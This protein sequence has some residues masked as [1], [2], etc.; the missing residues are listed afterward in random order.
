M[1][2]RELGIEVVS[3]YSCT[4]GHKSRFH[5][6]TGDSHGTKLVTSGGAGLYRDLHYRNLIGQFEGLY[7]GNTVQVLTIISA[8]YAL[9]RWA[10]FR[11]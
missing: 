2:E 5:C 4:G 1:R 10:P 9:P 8:H 11:N 6:S 3:E 7:E